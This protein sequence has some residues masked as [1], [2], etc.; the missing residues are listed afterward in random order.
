MNQR[1]ANR[2]GV[3]PARR[4]TDGG[5]HGSKSLIGE[6]AQP[7]GAGE[8]DERADALINAEEVDVEG[9]KLDCERYAALAMALCRGLVAQK[10]VSNA[11]PTLHPDGAGRVLGSLRDDAAVFRNRQGA[12]DVAKPY[13][14]E[15]QTG[16][17]AQ[18]ACAVL[19]SFRKRKSTLDCGANLIAVSAGEHR[20]L[21]QGFLK[22]HLLSGAAAG[23]VERRQR[24]FTPTPAFL[25]QRQSKEQRR[26]RGGE[27]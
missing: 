15:V 27:F 8:E 19:A 12:A 23:V 6:A 13:E 14:K 26:R 17:K 7:Q 5:L 24:P 18:L 22:N 25:Q 21:R 9:T 20:R 11:Q 4:F 16:E 1:K 2:N 10:V 3:T